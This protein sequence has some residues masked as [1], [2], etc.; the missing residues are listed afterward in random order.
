M[1]SS[2]FKIEFAAAAEAARKITRTVR[3]DFAGTGR[4]P[5]GSCLDISAAEP[6]LPIL[7]VSHQSR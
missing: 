4:I 7:V 5:G 2:D 6:F 1:V 3:R